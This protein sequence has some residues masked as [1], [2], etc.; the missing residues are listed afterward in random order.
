M[1]GF[2]LVTHSY[3]VNG[4]KP[5]YRGHGGKLTV[6]LFGFFVF[7]IRSGSG[8]FS[9]VAWDLLRLQSLILNLLIRVSLSSLRDR[10][11]TLA[12]DEALRSNSGS[13][14]DLSGIGEERIGRLA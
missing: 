11:S 12:P 7:T 10:S 8:T 4:E 9:V 13:R 3:D 1:T 2:S 14:T 6:I 5:A